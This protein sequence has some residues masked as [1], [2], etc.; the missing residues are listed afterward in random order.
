MEYT[1]PK[2]LTVILPKKSGRD[3]AGHVSVRHQGGR[4]KRFYR[5]IDWKRDKLALSQPKIQKI[6]LAAKWHGSCM[7]LARGLASTLHPKIYAATPQG[8]ANCAYFAGRSLQGPFD[9]G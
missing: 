2:S 3:V 9:F 5:V 6:G 1:T 7:G 4:H 8:A